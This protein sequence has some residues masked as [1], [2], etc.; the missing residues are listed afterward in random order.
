MLR[1]VFSKNKGIQFLER[2]YS[3]Y[4]K[5]GINLDLSSRR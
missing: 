4:S 5:I 1:Q 2:L 3:Q